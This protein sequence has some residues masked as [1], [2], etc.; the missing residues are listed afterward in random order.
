[1]PARRARTVAA[2]ATVAAVVLTVGAAAPPAGAAPPA[3]AGRAG[4][5]AVSLTLVTGD[6]VTLSGP[7]PATRV[8]VAPG[9]G[10]ERVP[11][12]VF[13][14]ASHV[15]VVPADAQILIDHGTVDPR[16]F[17]VSL[18]A[19]LHYGASP[20]IVGYAATGTGSAAAAVAAAGASVRRDLPALHAAAVRPGRTGSLW[21]Q[22]VAHSGTAAAVPAPGIARIWLDGVERPALDQ[23]VPQIGAPVAWAAGLDGTGISVAVLDTGVDAGHPDLAGKVIDQ[24]NFTSEPDTGDRLGH[25]THVASIIAGTGAASG[26]RYRG[27]APGATLYNG[28]VCEVFGCP[29]SAILAGM[30][31]AAADKHARVVNLSLGGTDFATMDPLEDAVN[32]LSAA[33]GTLFVI[34]AG[35]EGPGPYTVGSPG[36]ADAALTVGAADKSDQLA[37]FSSRGPRIGDDGLKPDILAPG[38]GIVAARASGTNIGDVVDQYY[39]RLSGTSMATPHVSGAAAILAEQHPQWSGAELKSALMGSA[40][41]LP[42]LTAWDQ[43]A[44][45]VDV[46]REITQ[47]IL[48]DPA[49][50]SLGRVAWPHTDDVPIVRTLTY[51]NDGAADVSLTVAG[52]LTGPDGQ[53][54]PAAMRPAPA[55]GLSPNDAVWVAS[56]VKEHDDWEQLLEGVCRLHV[57]GCSVDWEGFDRPYV[58][59]KVSLPTYPFQRERYWVTPAVPARPA[60]V[61]AL[62]AGVHPLLGRPQS[63]APAIPRPWRH[64]G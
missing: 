19:G 50:L 10:R 12:S 2:A 16:L 18:L 28:K 14:R 5:T 47:T 7:A 33:Y 58:R 34:A 25:G 29:D 23:S 11:F 46:A 15:Q 41:P 40:K 30:Q 21:P 57:S 22:L 37:R 54:G 27:V 62:P 59:E 4:P 49:S 60:S 13:R 26:G 56:L 32:T 20:L 8:A 17:D 61:D 51:H 24:Q 53:P 9:P 1:M 44:G 48:A 39:T 64:S 35:N 31:W 43:G 36:S 55:P 3:A 45:R 52:T 63:L 42:G 6:T 38:V